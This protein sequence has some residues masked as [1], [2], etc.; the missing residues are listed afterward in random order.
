MI[1]DAYLCTER[2]DWLAKGFLPLVSDSYR[3]PGMSGAWI[4]VAFIDYG[5]AETAKGRLTGLADPVAAC[6][7]DP[8]V[9]P[10]IELIS[11]EAAPGF[12]A[13]GYV[14]NDSQSWV[15]TN[16]EGLT[17]LFEAAYINT[18]VERALTERAI[19]FLQ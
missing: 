9:R 15:V 7:S 19:L 17:V 18:E 3:V 1:D 8:I 4:D 16:R 14:D 5:D 6:A 10:R 13:Y 2:I 11:P 12:E